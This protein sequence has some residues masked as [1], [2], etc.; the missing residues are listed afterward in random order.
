MLF[1]AGFVGE[2]HPDRNSD[3]KHVLYTHKIINVQY[4][5]NQVCGDVI[6]VRYYCGVYCFFISYFLFLVDHSCKSHSREPKTIRSW[7][8]TGHD[9]FCEMDSNKC[10]F[11]TSL[12]CVS[13]LSIFWAS[14]EHWHLC[15]DAIL[16][17]YLVLSVFA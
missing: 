15:V 11:C 4:N 10:L 6:Y 2:V 3:N 7:E 17:F 1:L 8:K 14:G 13:G 16:T 5:K 12:W 9:I